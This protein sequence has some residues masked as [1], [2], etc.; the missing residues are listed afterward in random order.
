MLGGE[1]VDHPEKPERADLLLQAAK[2]AGH[3]ILSPA[4]YGTE[5]LEAIHTPRY[6]DFLKNGYAEWQRKYNN[7]LKIRPNI[8]PNY[9]TTDHYCTAIAG[10]AGFHMMDMACSIGPETWE[11][12]RASANTAI[13]A[14]QLMLEGAPHAY[15]LCRPP[16][17]H[18]GRE[19]ISGFCYLNNVALA[20]QHMLGTYN[21]LVALDVDVHHGNGT[22]DVFYKRDDVF[23]ISIHGDPAD[24][25]PFH[26]GH[27]T[28][29]G[30]GKGEGYNLNIPLPAGTEDA[31]YMQVLGDT[32]KR[33]EDYAP[34]ALLVSLGLDAAEEDPLGCFN[35]S[36]PGFEQMGRVIG[37][38]DMPVLLVQEGGYLCDA[39]GQNL[40]AFL[41][42]FTAVREGGA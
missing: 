35:L 32:C 5:L 15:A 4:D 28:E 8:H 9:A 3:E 27:A 33:I 31:A 10:R 11:T 26:W 34:D 14:A 24:F 16:G 12:A 22:Q 36:T 20:A 40:V 19:Q 29:T 13:H 18:A 1:L 38:L 30:E 23:T 37:A 21:R 2:N 17:H 39:L 25:Y 41:K 6:L 7:G 42:G